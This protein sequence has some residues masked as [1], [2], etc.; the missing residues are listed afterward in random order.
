MP[1]FFLPFFFVN[2]TFYSFVAVA[3]LQLGGVVVDECGLTETNAA[4]LERTLTSGAASVASGYG[5]LDTFDLL[6]I[7]AWASALMLVVLVVGQL[8][9]RACWRFPRTDP[10]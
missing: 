3:K 10:P 7:D 1:P 9:A 4:C 2:P 8:R 6:A 5:L